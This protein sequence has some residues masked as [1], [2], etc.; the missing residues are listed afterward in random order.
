M[1]INKI[2]YIQKFIERGVYP[3]VDSIKDA[4]QKVP[5]IDKDGYKYFLSY[6]SNVSD[7]RT[8]FFNKWDKRSPFKAYNM[9]LY[10]SRVQ[11]NVQIVS[12]D[13]EL[14]HATNNKIKFICP[15]CGEVY[16]K[17]WCHWIAQPDNQH[18]CRKCSDKIS[19]ERR[20]YSY[21]EIFLKFQQKNFIL[22][23]SKN[24]FDCG[25]GRKRLLCKDNDG[26]LY[27]I[28]LNSLVNGNKKTNKFSKTN[29][30][31]VLNFQKWCDDNNIPLKINNQNIFENDRSNFTITCSCGNLYEAEA[32]E[33]MTLKRR[34]CPICSKKESRLELLTR[35][36]LEANNIEFKAQYRFSDCKNERSLPFDFYCVYDGQVIL[37]EVDGG[38]HFHVTQW[39]NEE[40]LKQQKI[41]D[42][43]KTDYATQKGYKLLRLPF[44]EF[45]N[46]T[47]TNHLNKTFFNI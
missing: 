33:V 46:E 22:L 44:W 35:E 28:S 42:K 11:E 40:A 14:F 12:T 41:R 25:G 4:Y 24:G 29:P 43:I 15:N 20:K 2:D 23:E 13:D 16:E 27:G 17:K 8:I 10:A 1:M 3:L 30:Y 37:I 31:V 19:V 45:D 39:T 26:Y 6:H 18:F 36:W 32:F 34:R 5:C 38:Q 47:Y 9:R 7:K 21:E